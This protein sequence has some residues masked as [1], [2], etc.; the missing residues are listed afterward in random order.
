MDKNAPQATHIAVRD[1]IILAVGDSKCAEAWGEF[2]HEDRF[3]DKVI[4]PGLVEAHAHVIAGGVWRLRYLGHYERTDP[5]G[6]SWP[7]IK[8]TARILEELRSE[9]ARNHTRM[10]I[11]W[12]YDPNFVS[13][14][15]I[16]RHMLDN[17]STRRPVILLHSNLHVLRANSVA[18]AEAQF[19]KLSNI[20]GVRRFPDGSL[21]GVLEEF[22]A[23]N[24]MLKYAG[25][26]FS[27]LSDESSLRAYGRL[28]KNS[29]V[30]T[31]A[32]LNSELHESEVQMLENVTGE[33]NFP[34]RYVPVMAATYSDPEEAAARAIALRSRSTVK[35]HLGAAKLFTDGAIQCRT[36]KLKPPGYL[37]GE[38]GGIWNMDMD[39]FRRSIGILHKAGVKT[40]IH[41]NGDEATEQCIRAYESAIREAPN[42]DLRH[43]LEHSQLAGVDQFKRMKALGLTVNLFAN[44]L[45]YF[46]DIHYSSTLGPDRASRMDA[47]AD[48]WRVFDGEFAIHSDA[49]VTP[50][51]PLRTAWCAVNRITADGLQLGEYQKISLVQALRCITLGAAHVLKLDDC[52][53]SI[54]CGKFA[55]FC[56]MEDDPFDI[57]PQDFA[58]IPIAAT[59]IGGRVIT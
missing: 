18:L 21:T 29:G 17:V 46:G 47:C 22:D 41:T 43:T 40:H 9:A 37:T 44:H 58:E 39:D 7:G 55:D 19:D 59:V 5:E 25:I 26:Q 42:P 1:G 23:I 13:G 16:D 32:D 36:A 57:G 53:G 34:V 30:T 10:I 38:D 52:V 11:A 6:Q 14:P 31:I 15:E 12:G 48:A 45:Y 3:S 51:D 27:D 8:T 24:P 49:P 20:E 56:V 28:A 35:L 4:L 54:Q 2:Q 50:L 33:D